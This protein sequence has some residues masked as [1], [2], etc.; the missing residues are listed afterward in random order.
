M[1][2]PEDPIKNLVD[3]FSKLPGIGERTALRLVLHLLGQK[4]EE[5]VGLSDA[6]LDVSEKIKEC[7]L[8]AMLTAEKE[9]CKICVSP[10]RDQSLLSGLIGKAIS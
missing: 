6:L 8:C 4:K 7:D 1:F 3:N 10:V 9:I 2:T 5:L